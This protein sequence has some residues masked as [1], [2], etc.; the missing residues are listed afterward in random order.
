MTE[1][2][3]KAIQ[4]I[5]TLIK[6]LNDSRDPFES[7]DLIEEREETKYIVLTREIPKTQNISSDG[8]KIL[9]KP[10]AKAIVSGKYGKRKREKV[11][12]WRRRI[13]H[14]YNMSIITLRVN[15]IQPQK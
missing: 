13:I 8:V 2:I 12:D 3:T 9:R 6:T 11:A 15:S 1:Y 7:G 10:R 5:I 14:K 4:K